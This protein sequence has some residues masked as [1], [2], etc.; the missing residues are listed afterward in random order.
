MCDCVLGPVPPGGTNAEY[1]TDTKARAIDALPPIVRVQTGAT[2]CPAP[3]SRNV[4]P[5]TQHD[6]LTTRAT[7]RLTATVNTNV[8]GSVCGNV[9]PLQ[10][11]VVNTQTCST[12]PIRGLPSQPII[13][14]TLPRS[15]RIDEYARPMRRAASSLVTR[16]IAD[17]AITQN[18]NN[19]PYAPFRPVIPVCPVVSAAPQ[20]GVPRAP[21][22]CYATG[23][24]R[25]DLS[26]RFK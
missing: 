25:V 23:Q 10:P 8:G 13:V 21:N 9:L 5:P 18:P 3:P 19:K 16:R 6:W 1:R 22:P 7:E 24:R 12:G 14:R 4:M 17:N 2:C 26:S 15:T 20:P 11:I